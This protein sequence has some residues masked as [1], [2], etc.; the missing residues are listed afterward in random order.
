MEKYGNSFALIVQEFIT[1]FNILIKP[2]PQQGNKTNK[3][4]KWRSKTYMIADIEN[5]I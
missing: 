1:L 3:Y 5:S 4:C 2:L